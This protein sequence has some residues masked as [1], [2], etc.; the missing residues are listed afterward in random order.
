MD[1]LADLNEPQRRAVLH[2]DGPLLV[3]A[4]AGSGK[5]RVIT[6]R[7]A[8]LIARGVAP[9]NILAIT[10]T[11]KAAE[12][13][14]QRVQQMQSPPGTTLCTF[15]A[16]CA[17][18][19]RELATEA[20][21]ERNFT[22]YDRDDQLRLVK[23]AIELAPGAREG[24]APARMLANISNAKNALQWPEDY[25]RD[26]G[27]SL[28]L[29][30]AAGVYRVY[31]RLLD[32]NNAL[33]FDDLLLRVA[34]LL[35][36]R[37]EIRQHLGQRYRYVL[38]DEYQ[39]TNHAQYLIAQGIAREHGNLCVTG[40]PDQSI[41]AWRGA[42]INNILDF[43]KD[44]PSACVIRL[45]ENYR[46]TTPI[47]TAA[48][49]LISHNRRRKHK[50]LWTTRQGGANVNV[51]YCDNQH[52]EADLI[53]RRALG[54]RERGGQLGDVA[55]FYRV[56]WLSRVIEQALMQSGVPYR[57][58]RGVEFYNRKEI[59]DVLGYL[60]LMANPRD[61]VA[62]RRVINTPARG[63]GPT[64]VNKL[65]A[66]AET[67]GLNLLETCRRGAEAGLSPA[68]RRKVAAFADLIDSL[69]QDVDRPVRAIVEDVLLRGGLEDSLEGD[70]PQ[71]QA[72]RGNVAELITAAAQFD[73]FTDGGDL[74]EY[75]QQVSLVSDTD[76][77][78]GAGGAVTLMTLHAAKG[79]EFPV[80]FIVGCEDGLLPI[81]R[82]DESPRTAAE[83]EEER[84]LAFVGMT[85]A[86]D[87]LIMTC[88][89]RRMIRG[90]TQPQAASPFITEIGD[91]FVTIED[92]TTARR[93]PA[94]TTG[95]FYDDVDTRSAIEA[96]DIDDAIPAEYEY[97]RPGCRVA[98]PKFGVGKL[99]KLRR[100]WPQTTA[101][102]IFEDWGPKKIVLLHARLELLEE[103]Y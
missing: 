39:D 21:L 85:R 52:A 27:D 73:R 19:L 63:I 71:Q 6:R 9:W 83:N 79:L 33:D 56:N 51:V 99:I 102:I 97:L 35:R 58:A 26:A 57:I 5:T 78:E 81:R 60:K 66:L 100:P 90:T 87:E 65:R 94:R 53:V 74:G 30:R 44:H 24:T 41:Y 86:K 3:L 7:V 82:M 54:Y 46:S 11:N 93:P 40:D 10:F 14:R 20:R 92:T 76:H 13:M 32:E 62:C 80:V 101:E 103:P 48:S 98:H 49:Q 70:D 59:R 67:L 23:E 38:I 36:D 96:I 37:P 34:F 17:R 95:G 25:A 88:A 91:A 50:R 12:E 89:R 68:P 29:Q 84:R 15:H 18:L 72:A 31:Q 8:H 45:E 61:D 77:F 42:N 28:A 75:L 43:E 69:R 55:V 4:G 64:T 2:V 16:L 1:L 22:I 47:L